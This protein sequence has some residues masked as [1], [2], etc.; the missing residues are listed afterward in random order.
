MPPDGTVKFLVIG[1]I[2][3]DAP[4]SFDPAPGPIFTDGSAWRPGFNELSSASFAAAQSTPEGVV[5]CGLTGTVPGDLPQTAAAGKRHALAYAADHILP[6]DARLDFPDRLRGSGY[7]PS[8]KRTSVLYCHR[9]LSLVHLSIGVPAF[10]PY[11]SVGHVVTH[12]GAR[13]RYG[14]A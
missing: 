3:T 11:R 4:P 10:S 7:A 6:L 13:S 12:C 9:C 1:G 8:P 5:I 2:A 14:A